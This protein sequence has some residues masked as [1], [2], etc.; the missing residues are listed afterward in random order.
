MGDYGLGKEELPDKSQI[1]NNS[2]Q[3]HASC[4]DAHASQAAFRLML[5]LSV[6]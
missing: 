4:A 3:A 6:I 2:G 5:P 1:G